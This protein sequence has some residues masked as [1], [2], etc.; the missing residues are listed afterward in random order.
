MGGIVLV[1]DD[2]ADARLLSSHALKQAGHQ[3]LL[4]SNGEEAFD[5]INREPKP[6][7]ILLDLSMPKMP[8]AEFMQFLKLHHMYG[9]VKVALVSGWED[10]EEQATILGADGFLR[11]P[12]ALDQLTSEVARLLKL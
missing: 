10:V 12:Y 5:I 6:Q 9:K 1:I 4:A 7:V 3:V 2:N 8:G 11:K